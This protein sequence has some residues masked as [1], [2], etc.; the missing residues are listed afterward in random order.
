MRTRTLVGAA[1]A[2]GGVV[3]AVWLGV[4]V[5]GWIGASWEERSQL[6]SLAEWK[7]AMSL[8][9]SFDSLPGPRESRPPLR[10]LVEN[11]VAWTERWRL[12][13]NARERVDVATFIVRGDV[14][15]L[16]FL[17]YLLHLAESGID[18]R[19][20]VDAHGTQMARSMFEED[21]LDELVAAGIEIRVYRPMPERIVQSLLR[22]DPLA[23]I[24]SEHDKLLLVDRE[25]A[26]LGG[27][28]I[29]TEYFADPDEHPRA[30]FDAD[31]Q[32][33]DRET[34]EILERAF[35]AEWESEVAE[36]VPDERVDVASQQAELLGAY[37]A[38]DAWLRRREDAA[39]D[40]DA[41]RRW[42]DV[43]RREHGALHG[44][45]GRERP[46]AIRCKVAILDSSPRRGHAKD[47]VS[48]GL[49][50]L[51]ASSEGEVLIQSP[52]LVLSGEAVEQLEEA[53]RRGV[54]ITIAT[55]SPSS[56]D[57]ALSQAFFLAQWPELLARVPNMRIF[58]RGDGHNLHAKTAV[59][60]G[61]VAVVGTYNLD[62]VSMAV[63]G[64]V[65]LVAEST[66]F[67]AEVAE[68]LR[69]TVAAG[70]P[71][72][73]E[74]R[75]VRG[76]DGEP[77]VGPD[78]RPEIAFGPEQHTD[79]ARWTALAAWSALLRTARGVAGFDPIF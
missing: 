37:R 55:N 20:L 31:V 28:N 40:D 74:Y 50:R 8:A 79:P 32:L 9:Q 19:L 52:Y 23:A 21:Y 72:A 49:G 35:D 65:A 53:G 62:P 36:A 42:L 10:L 39:P 54:S 57:N 25:Q 46:R 22:L 68:P 58:A 43:L 33:R 60:D 51:L 38:M 2:I 29:G 76:P 5:A 27:R 17:G 59:F 67:A 44:A 12:L 45:L 34:T 13:G 3:L 48:Q 16:S 77:I 66:E 78:G 70:P 56:S 6:G 47:P 14:F 7:P 64:E 1:A 75:I 73:Y 4:R 11:A 69:R 71:L 24:A 26:L 15:G 41:T 30:F 18:I 63:N 61:R